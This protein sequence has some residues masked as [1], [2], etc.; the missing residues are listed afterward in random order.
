[1]K[2]NWKLLLAGGIALALL[3]IAGCT[4]SGNPFENTPLDDGEKIAGF[5]LGLWHGLICPIA[6]VISLFKENV[7]FYEVHNNGT[8]YNLGYI[9]G[10]AGVFGG[11]SGSAAGKK[12]CT[13]TLKCDESEDKCI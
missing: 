6:F 8:W 11:C 12:K 7:H 3:M 13:P 5:W 1:M 4:A 2:L 9:I 10:L